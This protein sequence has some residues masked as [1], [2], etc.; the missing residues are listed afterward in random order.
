MKAFSHFWDK[1]K[2][3]LLAWAVCILLLRIQ[4]QDLFTVAL[5]QCA[6]LAAAQQWHRV[7]L[8]WALSWSIGLLIHMGAADPACCVRMCVTI[9]QNVTDL[10]TTSTPHRGTSSPVDALAHIR[11]K[12]FCPDMH[13]GAVADRLIPACLI[14][15]SSLVFM[16]AS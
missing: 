8:P 15:Q 12:I 13:F 10:L 1:I 6:P 14:T 2:G 7:S 3:R 9:K 16:A 11:A 5:E 4:L